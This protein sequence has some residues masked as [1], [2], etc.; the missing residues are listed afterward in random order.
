MK[1]VDRHGQHCFFE[2]VDMAEWDLCELTR[3]ARE[4]MWGCSRFSKKSSF[5]S[6]L[7]L[8]LSELDIHPVIFPRRAYNL[9]EK[10]E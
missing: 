2:S 8:A 4:V 5:V 10:C 1:M 6:E 7:R 3:G 9:G